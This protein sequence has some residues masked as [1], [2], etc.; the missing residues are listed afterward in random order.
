MRR[1]LCFAMLLVGGLH[2]TLFAQPAPKRTEGARRLLPAPDVDPDPNIP[3]LKQ[4]LDFDWAEEI[5]DHTEVQQYL[6]ALVKAAPDRTKLVRYGTSYERRSLNYLV[7][8]SPANRK[9]LE[10]IRLDNLLLS[11]PRKISDREA[12]TLVQHAPAVVWL[13]HSVH[14]NEI[15]PTDSSLLTAYHLLADRGEKTRRWLEQLIVI[16]DPLQNPDGRERFL[17][18]FTKHRGEFVDPNPLAGEHAEPWPSGR[19]NHYWFD[20]NRDWFLHSQRETQAKVKAYLDWQPQI[21][22]DAHEMGRNATYFF[23]PPKH[24]INPFILPRQR[25]WYTRI[26]RHQA[27]RFDENGIR[28]TTR[29]MF[30]AFYPGYGSKWPAHQGGIG[31]LWEQASTRGLVT[32]RDDETRLYFSDCVRHHYVSALATVEVAAENR[33][34][35]LRDFHANQRQSIQLGTDGPVRHYFLLEEDRPHRAARLAQVLVNNRIEVHR[36]SEPTT[37]RV[38][39]IRDAVPAD[40]VI[41]ADSYHIPLAQPAGRLARVLLELDVPMDEPFVSRQ[42]RRNALFLPDEI[43]DVT[44]WSLPLAFGVTCLAGEQ[45]ID[46]PGTRYRS[47]LPSP[48]FPARPP[49]VAYLVP[50]TDGA[51]A[52][53]CHWLRSG[54]RVHVINRMTKLDGRTYAP[55]TL[56]LFAHHAT[57][58][59]HESV[60]EAATRFGLTVYAADSGFVDEGAHLGGPHVKWVRPP[61]V[62]IVVDRPTSYRVGHTWHLFDQRMHYPT[63]RV[64]ARNLGRVN[65]N[66]FN[67]L[68]LPDGSYSD[69]YGFDK[70]LAERLQ[71]WT[72]G[73]GTLLLVRGAAQWAAEDAIGL[74]PTT[75]LKKPVQPIK[76]SGTEQQ[77]NLADEKPT[78]VSPDAAPGVFLRASVLTEH[79]LTFGCDEQIDVFYSGNTIL[80]PLLPT[81]GR[82]VV[83]FAKK[84][85][86]RTSGFCWVQTLELLAETPYLAYQ[87]KGS[88]HIIASADAP[89]YRA[90]YPASQGLFM[91]A[92]RFGPGHRRTSRYE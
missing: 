5:T 15:S 62:L 25:E 73:G 51:I 61:Q 7:I 44:A 76:T 92:G 68:V 28:Y 34:A 89:K 56:V 12:A 47:Q 20:M 83:T 4:V 9:R 27:R 6:Y 8:T 70:T 36:V 79:W 29:E 53:L 13:A 59:L 52:A 32:N 16:I 80:R 19:S 10:E 23:M 64:A 90:M 72:S 46:V 82:N 88:G 37:I 87:S 3:T 50:G 85:M 30:D 40:R 35:L 1:H 57:D 67:V 63:T 75:R 91:N 84:E 69:K 54:L 33:A 77:P 48:E 71:R 14:G 31:I 81:A 26:G 45:S 2:G 42:L 24:P 11:D 38:R 60:R 86:L 74:L 66:D 55:G 41:P 65:L 39:D 43:Y 58:A 78:M 18:G 49:K 22:V 21:Y 17:H